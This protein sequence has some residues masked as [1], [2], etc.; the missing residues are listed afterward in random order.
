VLDLR[1]RPAFTMHQPPQGYRHAGA[2]ERA[3]VDAVLALRELSGEFEKPRF[4]RY[5]DK[6]CA[7]SRNERIGCSAC[8]DVCSA[9][10]IRSDASRKGKAERPA[11]APAGAAGGT[12]G[13]LPLAV[14]GGVLVE[15]TCA[16]AAAPAARSARAAR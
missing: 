16:S 1:E 9:R 5:N 11:A 6:L 13:T 7:H 15:P 8:I 10:A 4:F 2:D 14:G 3:L 12:A